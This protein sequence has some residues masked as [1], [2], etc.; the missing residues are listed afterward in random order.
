LHEV[1]GHRI[2][3]EEVD[4]RRALRGRQYSASSNQKFRCFDDGVDPEHHADWLIRQW[5][6][7]GKERIA[8]YR[9]VVQASNERARS[10]AAA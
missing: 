2:D 1:P 7:E 4:Q 8:S 5:R 9:Q 6:M 10:E 3:S